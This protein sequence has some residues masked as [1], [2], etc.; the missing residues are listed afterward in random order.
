MIRA[1]ALA[2]ALYAPGDGWLGMD[3]VKHFFMSAFVQS[4]SYSALRSVRV[5]HERA[6]VG[7]SVATFAVGVG[8]EIYDRRDYGL[9]SVRDLSWDVAGGVSASVLLNQTRR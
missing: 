6:L 1:L 3:K 8:K 2:A 9:F 5:D 7:A 4:V